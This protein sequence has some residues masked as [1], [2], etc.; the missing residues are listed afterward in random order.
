MRSKPDIAV[1]VAA[2]RDLTREELVDRWCRIY[3]SPPPKG[4]RQDLLIRAADPGISR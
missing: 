1:E 4:V 3:G 2:L